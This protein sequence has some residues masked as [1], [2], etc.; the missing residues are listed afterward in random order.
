MT[1]T[2][3]TK[4]PIEFNDKVVRQFMLASIIFGVVAMLAG[5]FIATQLNFH[6]L[7]L[8]EFLTFGRLRPLHTNAAIFAFVGNMMFAGVYYST[9]RASPAARNTPSSSGRSMWP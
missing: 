5:V 3:A 9:Q 4:V 8:A 6:Q 7:N 2:S 1:S